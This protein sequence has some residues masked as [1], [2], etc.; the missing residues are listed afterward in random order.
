[1]QPVRSEDDLK[2]LFR[3]TWYKTLFDVST[4]VNDGMGA[5]DYKISRGPKDKT[6]IEFKLASNTKLKSSL[7]KQTEIYKKASDAEFDIYVIVYFTESD[8]KR[9]IRIL[10]EL[11]MANKENII[12]VDARS[13]NKPT[14]SRA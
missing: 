13:D 11:G 2:M 10:N 12:L 9:V 3:L 7:Q 5:A 1:M 8:E 6:I 4:E 14:G